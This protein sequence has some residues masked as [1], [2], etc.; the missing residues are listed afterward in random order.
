MDDLANLSVALM[1]GRGEASRVALAYK[2]FD[3]YE[4]STAEDKCGFLDFLVQ[5]FDADS[6]RL[7]QAVTTYLSAPTAEAKRA[8]HDAAEP[9]RQELLR[10]LNIAPGGTANLVSMRR[11]LLNHLPSRPNLKLLDSDFTHL[12]SSWF[13]PGFLV[14]KRIDW[15]TPAIILEK[16]IRYEAV[17]E[18]NGWGDLRRRLDPGDRRC[19][20]FFH[21]SLVEEPLIFIEVALVR[22]VPQ[23]ISPLLSAERVP[24]DP[25]HARIAVFYSISNCQSGLKGISLGNF[26][27]K[28]VVEELCRD[29]PRLRKF[30]TLS[31]VPGF[32]QWLQREREAPRFL[33][34]KT[35]SAFTLLDQP[36]WHNNLEVLKKT[37]PILTN[38]VAHY[39]LCAKNSSGRPIDPVARFHL[40]NGARLERINWMGD[41]SSKGLKEGMGFMVNYLYDLRQIEHNHEA[42]ATIGE[43]VASRSVRKLLTQA[44]RGSTPSSAHR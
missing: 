23:S 25:S 9:R 17:H 44:L 18:I 12:F 19:F 22:S 28:Q 39:F 10:R 41:N 33:T 6:K 2:L 1:S 27:I 8:L 31:P 15:S 29:L 13:N 7:E 4:N 21:P 35:E 30:V 43:V 14:L 40:G 16:V 34:D 11:D 26:L 20:A 3:V 32:A 38:A 42:F 24:I 36:D 37:K 5:H